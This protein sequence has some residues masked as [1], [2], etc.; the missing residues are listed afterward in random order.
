MIHNMI[1]IVFHVVLFYFSHV[2]HLPIPTHQ[3][4]LYH[5]T[6]TN[7]TRWN[8]RCASSKRH[9]TKTQPCLFKLLLMQHT[10]RNMLS[11]VFSIM[12]PQMFYDWLVLE[13][14]IGER[15]SKP[16][17]AVESSG[18]KLAISWLEKERFSVASLTSKIQYWVFFVFFLAIGFGT[19][20]QSTIN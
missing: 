4:A 7:C 1:M 16:R 2:G 11:T 8:L 20:Q 5:T 9:E 10:R 6:D 3:P 13:W 17:M 19:V 15:A 18:F 14:L 12:S